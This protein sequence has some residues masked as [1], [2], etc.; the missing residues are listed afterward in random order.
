MHKQ[1]YTKSV[2]YEEHFTYLGSLI[3]KI[4]GVKPKY[5]QARLTK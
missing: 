3:C 2:D 5:I 1:A 4:N